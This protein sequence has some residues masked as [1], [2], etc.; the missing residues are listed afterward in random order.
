MV[1][2]IKMNLPPE[3]VEDFLLHA[4]M[5]CFPAA[6]YDKKI[7]LRIKITVGGFSVDCR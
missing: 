2:Y 5:H 1:S 7:K 6:P 3:V 4:G